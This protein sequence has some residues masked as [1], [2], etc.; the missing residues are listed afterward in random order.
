MRS[1]C[2]EAKVFEVQSVTLLVATIGEE[3]RHLFPVTFDTSRC[4][5]GSS[6]M[7]LAKLFAS[8]KF[9]LALLAALAQMFTACSGSADSGFTTDADNPGG[10]NNN[11]TQVTLT[12]SVDDGP[13]TQSNV[14]VGTAGGETVWEGTT[15]GQAEYS[16]TLMVTATEFPLILRAT[17]GT[18]LVTNAAPEFDMYSAVLST[19]ANIANINPFSTII[20]ATASAQTGGINSSGVQSA[21]EVVLEQLSFGL[22]RARLSDPITVPVQNSNIATLVR[23]SEALAE[24]IR[25]THAELLP[26]NP[27]LSANDVI[28]HLSTDLAD[29]FIDGLGNGADARVAATASIVS[30]QVLIE[31]MTNELQ[32]GGFAAKDRM[33]AA[34]AMVRPDTNVLTGDLT[35]P[36]EMITQAG[37]TATAAYALSPSDELANLLD[38]LFSMQSGVSASA[39]KQILPQNAV[40]LLDGSVVRVTTGTID[41]LELVNDS[42]RRSMGP[43]SVDQSPPAISLL[44]PDP[45][46]L[47]VDQPYVEQGAVATDNRDG[48]IS[49][50][51]AIDNSSIDIAIAGDYIVTYNVS[52]SAGNA[53]E[54]V[55]RTVSVS[56]PDLPDIVAPI[57]TLV[58]ANPLTL[59]QG[60]SYIEPGATATDNIDGDITASIVIDSS[61]VTSS[62]LGNYAVTYNVSDSAANTADE[63]A[64]TVIVDS[65]PSLNRAW[66]AILDEAIGFGGNVTGGKG[67]PLVTVT[68]LNDSGAGSLR[69]VLADNPGG[70]WVR[71]SEGLTGLISLSTRLTPPNDTTIDG[72]GANITLSG[73]PN[74]NVRITAAGSTNFFFTHLKIQNAGID[75]MRFGSYDGTSPNINVRNVWIHHV[76]F[77]ALPGGDEYIDFSPQVQ[78][79]TVSYCYFQNHFR[80]ILVD[81]IDGDETVARF[82]GVPVLN[83]TSHHNW[84]N[85]I[86]ER[87]PLATHSRLHSYNNL[88]EFWA[89]AAVTGQ[90]AGEN[91]GAGILFEKSIG[92]ALGTTNPNVARPHETGQTPAPPLKSVGPHLLRNG[93]KVTEKDTSLVFDPS[94]FYPYTADD[95]DAVLETRIRANAGWQ[96]VAFPR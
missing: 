17:D 95:A 21:T 46:L 41:D 76:S 35:V 10:T 16:A 18:D 28:A 88:H 55:I 61:S 40:E 89:G 79:V 56:D 23:S 87:S 5:L 92:D 68:N 45:V 49:S 93:A 22:D 15:T 53:A 34:I 42:V 8:T 36:Q 27:S 11:M 38:S 1:Q 43:E 37:I 25:R 26:T 57:I 24:M 78:D 44:G 62:T 54:Q 33:D 3:A 94:S 77:L 50:L 29:G 91:Q 2:F 58:G 64:R 19:N 80:G 90:V 51:L 96:N 6:T 83:L 60:D 12:G 72:R 75:G 70:S 39:A 84:F 7:R 59:I 9:R 14:Y 74:D 69:Q 13:V 48:D 63:I 81:R 82:A 73:S 65:D 30:A 67:K 66:E 20:H 32:V 4:H 31:T 47:I 85:N 86:A 71:F 52:D